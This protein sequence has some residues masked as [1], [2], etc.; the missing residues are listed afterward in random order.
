VLRK[1]RVLRHVDDVGL[2]GQHAS[3]RRLAQLRLG[4]GAPAVWTRRRQFDLQQAALLAL[5][6]NP[7][8]HAQ[9]V[10]LMNGA[11]MNGL[12]RPGA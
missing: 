6:A 7:A 11:A 10:Q 12:E 2:G 5:H 8:E 9:Q 3:H 4:R 1:P